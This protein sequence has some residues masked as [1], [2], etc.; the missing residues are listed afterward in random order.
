[1][2]TR[3]LV[4]GSFLLAFPLVASLSCVRPCSKV[5]CSTP[6]GCRGGTVK[7]V[8]GCCTVCAKMEGERCGGQWEKEGRCDSGL[9]CVVR[10]GRLKSGIGQCEPAICK[11]KK[12]GFRE[13]CTVGKD[14]FPYCSCSHNCSSYMRNPVCGYSNGKQYDNKCELHKEEC[15]MGQVIGVMQGP[16]KKCLY[17]DRAFLFGETRKGK[18][19]CEKC[20]CFHGEWRCRRTSQCGPQ[21]PRSCTVA[22]NSLGRNVQSDCPKGYWCKVQIPGIPEAGIP[23]VAMCVPGQPTGDRAI[24]TTTVSTEATRLRGP[25]IPARCMEPPSVG[26]CKAAFPRW[27][28]NKSKKK[29]QEFLYGGCDGN[30]NNFNTKA[31]CK[32]LCIP[33]NRSS[34][35]VVERT[36]PSP[37]EKTKTPVSTLPP[38]TSGSSLPSSTSEAKKKKDETQAVVPPAK[39][40]H[41]A[42]CHDSA[43]NK[44]Y[45]EGD[46]WE[47]ND[48]TVCV[49]RNGTQ[50][51]LATVCRH[52]EC[53]EPIYIKGQCCPVCPLVDPTSTDHNEADLIKA[54]AG[55]KLDTVL[56]SINHGRQRDVCQDIRS[57]QYYLVGQSW[58]LDQCT[59]CYCGK[60]G[61]AACALQ[62]CERD[63]QCKDLLIDNSNCCPKCRDENVVK[64]TSKCYDTVTKKYYREAELWQRDECTSCYCGDDRKPVCTVTSC[65][66]VYCEAPM[67]IEQRCCPVCPVKVEQGCMFDGQKFLH[68]DL[69]TLQD[70]CTLCKCDNGDWHCSRDRCTSGQHGGQN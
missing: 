36:T 40:S 15:T 21:K 70:N 31:A 30:A 32:D 29:C 16:C 52:P 59:T 58:Q 44:F 62:M 51:C 9:K 5:R 19:P 3:L 4:L 64:S 7:S 12:C 41:I 67:K 50:E 54:F 23:E 38:T 63:P 56:V 39:K 34:K 61:K 26:P 27:Y 46:T 20:N 11:E 42:K 17:R 55:N 60:S 33:R 8:C 68:G 47:P 2:K 37:M 6:V 18:H 57:G 22:L 53:K 25:K 24:F 49:C 13:V 48:C 14:G 69:K 10:G 45:G 66:P 35:Q 43:S 1:M 28:Y 65:P